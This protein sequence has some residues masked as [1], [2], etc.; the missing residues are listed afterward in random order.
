M[1]WNWQQDDWPNFRFNRNALKEF[2]SQ[3]LHQS[4][5]LI[6]ATKYFSKDDKTHL[7]V[8]LMTSEAIKT[9]EIEGEYLNRDSVQSSILRN[10]GL[11]TDNRRV[12]PAER[13][14]ADM[15]TDLYK[16]F[17]KQLSH[18]TLY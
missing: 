15:M 5:V 13:G 8:E 9:S 1:T 11:K 12:E 18:E 17:D 3:F 7:I 2:E 4:G 6:G 10:F 14:I 16:H